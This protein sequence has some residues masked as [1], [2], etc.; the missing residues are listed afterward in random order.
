MAARSQPFHRLSWLAAL[1]PLVVRACR[2]SRSFCFRH[3]LESGIEITCAKGECPDWDHRSVR[4]VTFCPVKAAKMPLGIRRMVP[5]GL[6]LFPRVLTLCD[7]VRPLA[8]KCALWCDAPPCA[9]RRSKRGSL[10]RYVDRAKPSGVS[11]W[12]TDGGSMRCPACNLWN[13]A[14][15]GDPLL[16]LAGQSER[17]RCHWRV[18]WGPRRRALRYPPRL[19]HV[20]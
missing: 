4:A 7:R 15:Q 19:A 10:R 9:G 2:T 16:F 11:L 1:Y 20:W 12:A 5:R 14:D 13:G 3:R 6:W 18:I 8:A 17:H